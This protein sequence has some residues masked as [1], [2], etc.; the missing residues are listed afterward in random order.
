MKICFAILAIALRQDGWRN[1]AI[2]LIF[3]ALSTA[4]DVN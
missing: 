3:R 1:I 4:S 2:T